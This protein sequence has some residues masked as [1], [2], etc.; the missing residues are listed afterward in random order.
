MRFICQIL[1]VLCSIKCHFPH[2][3]VFAKLVFISLG[4][5]KSYSESM[6]IGHILNV[7]DTKHKA[8]PSVIF[9][10]FAVHAM[11]GVTLWHWGSKQQ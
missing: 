4:V 11:F 5:H 6:F 10:F 8:P 1:S 2:I 7:S 9:L 3:E